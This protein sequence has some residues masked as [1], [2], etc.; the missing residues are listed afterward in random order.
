MLQ[1]LLILLKYI[2]ASMMPLTELLVKTMYLYFKNND[3]IIF[4]L[5]FEPTG[6]AHLF[7]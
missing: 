2:N 4:C 1:I 5:F 6:L 7:F 3:Q